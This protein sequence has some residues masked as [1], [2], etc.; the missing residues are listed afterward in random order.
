MQL[1]ARRDAVRSANLAR[2]RAM[3]FSPVSWLPLREHRAL[4]RPNDE[5]ALRAVAL[6]AVAMWIT[7]DG[8][9]APSAEIQSHVARG[10]LR[11]VLDAEE[12]ALLR[13]VQPPESG[14]SDAEAE[15]AE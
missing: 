13:G 4:V 5:I 14:D 8:P 3:G 12:V 15:L 11:D 2:L 6:A 10:R 9:D 7:T 1:I